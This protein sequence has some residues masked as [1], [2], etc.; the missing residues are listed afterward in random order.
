LLP[1]SFVLALALVSQGVV[2]TFREPVVAQVEQ[3]AKAAD[4]SVIET[5]TIQVGPV[6]SQIA[7]KQLGTNGGGFFNANSAH[8]IENPTPFSN[9]LE[10]FAILAI[11]AG[12]CVTFGRMVDDERQGRMLLGAM[13]ALF[14]AF[15][16]ACTAAERQH[17]NL[18]REAGA[19]ATGGDSPATGNMEGKETRFGVDASALWA[20][21]TTSA[22]NGSV[23]SM[24]DSFTPLGG[25]VPLTLMLLGE[26]VYGGVGCGLYGMLMFV[27][28]TVFISGLLVGRTPEFLG[29]KVGAFEMKMASI[30]ILAPC[31]AVLVACAIAVVH[32]RGPVGA[33]NPGCHG[34]SEM[35]YA[36]ASASNNNGSAFAGLSA[37]TPFWNYLLGFCMLAGR[38]GTMIPVLAIAGSLARRK[39][40]P[41]GPGTL[42]T[43]T[44]L[45]AALLIG[46]VLLVGALNFVPA[47]FLG[48]I[49]EHVSAFRS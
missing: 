23:N 18:L 3:Q 30:A 46:V 34:F 6:A 21:A 39:V 36:C 22:S 27:I 14:L 24:H 2:Q 13:T 7:I 37:N 47:L 4:G 28:V 48:P 45:F 43:H 19:A 26:V 38:F 15:L 32:P 8:P 42:P 31:I 11:S 10:C 44:P 5:Q 9:F 16:V 1:L 49:V 33:P 17:S 35:L 40:A 41:E 29:K 25:L 20:T 12:C